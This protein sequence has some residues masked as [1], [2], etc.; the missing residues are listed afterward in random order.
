[1]RV[2]LCLVLAIGLGLLIREFT[3]YADCPE[4]YYDNQPMQGR[5][6]EGRPATING[7]AAIS[8]RIDGSW[9][10]SP[11]SHQTVPTFFNAVQ[12]AI[13]RWNNATDVSG[14]PGNYYFDLRQTDANAQITIVRD[15]S[16]RDCAITTGDVGGPYVIHIPMY[17]DLRSYEA[18]VQTLA[19]ELGHP[20]GLTHPEG[21]CP[22]GQSIMRVNSGKMINGRYDG[23]AGTD[24]SITPNDVQKANTATAAGGPI[25]GACRRQA[26]IAPVMPP[27]PDPTNYVEPNYY[28]YP[29]CYFYYTAQDA[30][31]C[32]TIDGDRS[33]SYQ[34]TRY[35]LDY[36]FC[37]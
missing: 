13:G 14:Q 30:Y 11:G 5:A 24:R 22:G 4:C 18:L 2:I 32:V 33:C 36:V 10:T 25:A 29:T 12:D 26:A 21:S 23:C 20:Y 31:T 1:M 37:Y 35:Y 7:R 8:V 34:G 17:A 6:S 15:S 16:T 27:M 3:V 28:Y 9:D 19:H